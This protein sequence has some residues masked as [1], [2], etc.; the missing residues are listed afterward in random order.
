M[1]YDTGDV[2]QHWFSTWIVAW[3]YQAII[4]INVDLLLQKS[5]GIHAKVM[6]TYIHKLCYMFTHL[7]YSHISQ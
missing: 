3:Q 2:G 7:N 4:W 5:P 6:F 1:P